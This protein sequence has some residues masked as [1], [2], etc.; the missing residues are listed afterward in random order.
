LRDSSEI[1]VFNN[2]EAQFLYYHGV[3]TV[4]QAQFLYY[5]GV[6]TVSQAQFLYYLGVRTV[7]Q[8]QF[9]YDGL[10]A[11]VPVVLGHVL[12]ETEGSGKLEVL[13]DSERS[14][15][16]IILHRWGI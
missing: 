4:S 11:L 6:R 3:R 14:H 8:A 1:Y 5:L 10:H 7:S 16:N 13:P 15:D 9:L 2:S 12:R